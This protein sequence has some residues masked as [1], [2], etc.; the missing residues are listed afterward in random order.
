MEKTLKIF[1]IDP[2]HFS[3]IV[4]NYSSQLHFLLRRFTSCPYLF[5]G[6]YLRFQIVILAFINN[7]KEFYFTTY[8]ILFKNK[9]LTS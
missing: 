5:C 8:K 2:L 9:L 7:L 4:L 1:K 6:V 3:I